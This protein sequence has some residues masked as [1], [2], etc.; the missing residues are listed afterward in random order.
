LARVV[1]AVAVGTELLL[2]QIANTNGQ[3]LAQVLAE[4]GCLHYFQVTVG[5]NRRRLV[6]T[7]RQALG[8]ADMVVTIGGLGPTQDDL[9][10]EAVAEVF[11]RGIVVDEPSWERIVARFRGRGRPTPNNRRQA[12]IPE[13]A[14]AVRN[15]HGTAPGVLLE[16]EY[17]G[18]PRVVVCLPGPPNE[19]I[20]MT[21]G[22]LAD[23]LERWASAG[24]ERTV[25]LSRSLR[26]AGIG[27]S[28]VEHDIRDLID[29]AENPTIA[30]YAKPGEV[31]VRL[32][33]RTAAPEE[34]QAL[35]APLEAQVRARLDPW[36]YGADADTLGS[37]VIRELA[38]RGMTV[39]VAESCTGGLLSERLT[40][41]PGASAAFV[42]GAVTYANSAKNTILQVPSE[43]I[44]AHGAV[45]EEVARAMAE[46]VRRS[47]G[48][49][50]GVGITG[51][52]GPDGGTAE[53]PVGTVF[54]AIA[55]ADGTWCRRLGLG[56]DRAV[57]RWRASQDALVSLR[58]Y[59][60]AGA[61]A[62]SA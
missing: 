38:A 35:L 32:T 1:E 36:V 52:A 14:V 57:I 21:R 33:A 6:D 37:A 19:F 56:G 23:Y 9:T 10:K 16:A 7:L 49:S 31:E 2:G 3:I 51:V 11:G 62:F 45:S 59:V 20:P 25:L 54:V 26:V 39:A 47:A 12:E 24:G 30:T 18:R 34:A 48:A 43:A 5:D 60:L 42:C 50:V 41:G 22:F 8:R 4:H 29:A 28:Q 61:A 17:Q 53:K 27:E 55:A 13:G 46:G 15:D 40:D 44:A 58:R